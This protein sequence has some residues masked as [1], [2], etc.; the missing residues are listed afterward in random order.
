MA[1]T[2]T[3]TDATATPST[4]KDKKVPKDKSA[5]KDKAPKEPKEKKAPKEKKSP[6]EDAVEPVG[7]PS[8]VEDVSTEK[9]TPV[10]EVKGVDELEDLRAQS[11]LF[12]EDFKEFLSHATRIRAAH[13]DLEK[14]YASQLKSAYKLIRK[15]ASKN[16]NRQPCGF[17]K[18]AKISDELATFFD[19]PSGTKLARTDATKLINKYAA[20]NDLK[21]GRRILIDDKLEALLNVRDSGVNL[22]YFNLQRYM[23]RHFETKAQA[24]AAAAAAESVTV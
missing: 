17:V 2:T 3:T 15:R 16:I 19:L 9:D 4:Q 20:A 5:V 21:S 23:A 12:A 11:A 7:T 1:K 24:D 8:P 6:K 22:T 10:S 13:K 18:P 14:K